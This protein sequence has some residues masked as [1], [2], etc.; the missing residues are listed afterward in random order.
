MKLIFELTLPSKLDILQKVG[1]LLENSVK[2]FYP[3]QSDVAFYLNLAVTEA[4]SNAVKHGAKQEITVKITV[5]NLTIN[6]EIIDKGGKLDKNPLI[7]NPDPYDE[8]GRGLFIISK[9]VDKMEFIQTE[10]STIFTLTKNLKP[11]STTIN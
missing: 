4:L 1:E 9:I 5:E 2:N 7:N 10:D 3:N 8:S 11:N 6:I